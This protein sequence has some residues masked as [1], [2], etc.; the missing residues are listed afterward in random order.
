MKKWPLLA[1]LASTGCLAQPVEQLCHK[2]GTPEGIVC[3]VSIEQL[4]AHP[5][6]FDGKWVVVPGVLATQF[7]PLLFGSTESFQH[8]I[9]ANAVFLD[10]TDDRIRKRINALDHRWVQ[11]TGKFSKKGLALLDYGV[12]ATSGQIVSIQF[13]DPTAGPW[14]VVEKMPPRHGERPA[15]RP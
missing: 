6:Y 4:Q 14:G 13:V 11:V 5:G 8:S 10:V 1:L 3:D 15:S 2:V 9:V 12:G 7:R